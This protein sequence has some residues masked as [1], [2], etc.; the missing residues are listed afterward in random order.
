MKGKPRL[1]LV[2]FAAAIA[3]LAAFGLAN[4]AG[5][6]PRVPGP[7]LSVSIPVTRPSSPSTWPPYPKFPHAACW[8]TRRPRFGFT[9]SAPSFSQPGDKHP[10][11]PV[12][13]VR[14]LLS[15]F[16]DRR[17]IRG[18][19]LE[20]LRSRELRWPWG[21][22]APIRAPENALWAAID[23]PEAKR[24][25]G[26]TR[27]YAPLAP[28]SSAML[29]QWEVDLVGGALRDGLCDAGGRPLIGWGTGS[30]DG[31]FSA[32]GAALGQRFPNPSARE[33]RARVELVGRRY[34]F[35]VISLR[36]LRPRQFAP[37]LV[38]RTSRERKAFN[39]DV[40]EIMALLNPGV[41]DGSKTFEG[42]FFEALD[43]RGPFV[44]TYG[45]ARGQIRGDWWST[46]DVDPCGPH[47]MPPAVNE[48]CNRRR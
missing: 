32:R 13:I 14:R 15:G 17:F 41:A 9:R 18:I 23:A 2:G 12:E 1:A 22:V 24:T 29:A 44:R 16:G 11:A 4:S 46:V 42:F 10:T 35:R 38:V 28:E 47:S 31:S 45:L 36:L 5:A 34:G 25:S 3:A 37:L 33:F 40:L 30:S 27:I 8:G 20:P 43:A 48:A 21:A 6:G 39:R 7:D 26:L 19:E